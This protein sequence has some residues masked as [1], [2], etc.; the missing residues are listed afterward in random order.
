[1]RK[2]LA[3]TIPLL[4]AWGLMLALFKVVYLFFDFYNVMDV[5][6][7]GIA[8]FL[9]SGKMAAGQKLLVLLAALPAFLL[10]LF[11]VLRVGY[12]SILKGVGTSFAISLM[13]IPVATYI[14]VFI[15]S[16]RDERK[17]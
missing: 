14:G 12:E 5:I 2:N 10:S 17:R 4:L 6:V 1:M 9:L 15:R 16:K 13:V 7:F 8:G 11:F 3:K